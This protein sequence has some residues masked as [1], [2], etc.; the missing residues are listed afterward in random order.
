MWTVIAAL[1]S[2]GCAVKTRDTTYVDPDAYGAVE[3]TGIEARDVRTVATQMAGELLGSSALQDVPVSVPRLA[4]LP[5]KNRSRFLIDQEIFT[6]LITDLLIQNAAGQLAILNRDI[7]NE[8][9]AEREMK[10]NGEVDAGPLTQ[11]AGA[12]FFLQG[13]VR[14]LSASSAE[15]QSDYV[16]IRFQ[17]TNAETGIVVWSNSYEMKKEGS[18]GVMYQ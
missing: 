1:L 2:A 11:M 9:L 7:V 15:A 13:E 3:G 10:R 17:M 12:D 8:V 6:T 14:S 5:V 4:V 18:W 16:V